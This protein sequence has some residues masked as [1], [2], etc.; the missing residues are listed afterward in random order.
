MPFNFSE[1]LKY[2]SDQLNIE[3]GSSNLENEFSLLEESLREGETIITDPLDFKKITI[4]YMNEEAE[5]Y[6][7]PNIFAAMSLKLSSIPELIA[8]GASWTEFFD[9]GMTFIDYEIKTENYLTFDKSTVSIR[10]ESSSPK[11]TFTPSLTFT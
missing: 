6:G 9:A 1:G 5:K 10:N 8:E 3:D 4:D 11:V 7:Y 2:I